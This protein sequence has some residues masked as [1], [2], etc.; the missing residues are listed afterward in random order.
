MKSTGLI[1]RLI[2]ATEKMMQHFLKP[3]RNQ[4]A[5]GRRNTAK[6]AQKKSEC[7]E[8]NVLT[9]TKNTT[10]PATIPN[11]FK[12]LINMV[13]LQ[14]LWHGINPL[15]LFRPPVFIPAYNALIFI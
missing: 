7:R 10:T 14:R 4:N 9:A 6:R 11:T 12:D 1:A 8:E 15:Q 3:N 13:I 5:I 2:A